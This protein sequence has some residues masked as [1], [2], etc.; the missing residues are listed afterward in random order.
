MKK[1]FK[2]LAAGLIIVAA[3]ACLSSCK[4]SA[5]TTTNTFAYM[6]SGSETLNLV[7][8]NITLHIDES[9]TVYAVDKEKNILAGG[10]F[11]GSKS[12][13]NDVASMDLTGDNPVITGLKKGDSVATLKWEKD[14]FSLAK[15][16][17]IIVVE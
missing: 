8:G 9:C 5:S 17:N 11:A 7:S 12:S 13:S 14:G 6:I 15:I 3:A 4:K 10:D 16:V 1:L 2:I